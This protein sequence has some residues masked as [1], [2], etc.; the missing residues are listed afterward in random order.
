MMTMT[1]PVGIP[2][3]F[4]ARKYPFALNPL[5]L[6]P[7]FGIE[8]DLILY[9]KD[10]TGAYL[11]TT[12]LSQFWFK[13]G[14]GADIVVYKGLYVRPQALLGFKLHDQDERD[15]Q[16]TAQGAP[17]NA[18]AHASPT[19]SSKAGCRSAGASR[20]TLR[21]HQRPRLGPPSLG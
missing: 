17:Y 21:R 6:F 3:P 5:S 18:T 15:W 12:D 8:Y 9:Y 16:E 2:F 1:T 13:L 4:T 14:V 11:D 10:E 19:S 20:L 7:L